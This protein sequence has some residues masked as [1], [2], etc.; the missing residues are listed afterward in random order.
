M[1]SYRRPAHYPYS[2]KALKDVPRRLFYPPRSEIKI[3]RVRSMSLTPLFEV[4]LADVLDG[5][6]LPPLSRKDFEEYLLFAEHSAENLYFFEWLKGY[7]E[8]YNAWTQAG[9]PHSAPLA[10]SWSRAKQTFLANDAHF[11]LNLSNVALE[12]LPNA[13]EPTQPPQ[14]IS[15]TAM[16]QEPS[17]SSQARPVQ[18]SYPSPIALTKVR[19]EVEDMLRESLNRF[20]CG[21]C[22][23]SGRARGLFGISLGVITIAAGLAPVLISILQGRGGRGLRAAAIPIFWLGAWI[24]IMSLH[25]VCIL[26]FLFGDARQLYPYELARPKITPLIGEPR[27]TMLSS[28]E[29]KPHNNSEKSGDPADH[30]QLHVDLEQGHMGSYSSASTIGKYYSASSVE[31]GDH[32]RGQ[33]CELTV[34][35]SPQ[36]GS[37]QTTTQSPTS[38]HNLMQQPSTRTGTV[39]SPQRWS[40]DFDALPR[41]TPN[42]EANPDQ[43]GSTLPVRPGEKLGG[44]PTFGPLTKVL[45]PIVTRAQW[46]IVVRSA[47]MAVAV[48]AI[49]GAICLA[50]PARR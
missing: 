12:G 37:P 46:E 9:T 42:A 22:G 1:A 45:S 43:W 24:T 16:S 35:G 27:E 36:M 34:T 13:P 5:Q 3:G 28:P 25:G 21:S 17:G 49:L 4:K 14:P 38:A 41:S 19:S 40:F 30:V 26:I 31:R 50:V 2:F 29:A 32:T 33:S 23:N 10:L 20:V 39:T 15:S 7:T 44:I 48:A 18:P 6:H 8:A 11:K 47:I